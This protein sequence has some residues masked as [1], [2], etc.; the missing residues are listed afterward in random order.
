[1]DSALDE[2]DEDILVERKEDLI[3]LMGL[4]KPYLDDN[5]D[6]VVLGVSSDHGVRVDVAARNLYKLSSNGL[7]KLVEPY[8]PDS[9]WDYFISLHSLW[10]WV[11]FVFLVIMAVSIYL[12]PQ[13]YPLN[14]IRIGTSMVFTLYIPG[15][16]LIEALY[17]KGDDLER[18]ERFALSVGLSLA[19]VPLV[20]LVLN[21]TSFGI[22]L[23][24]S[25]LSLSTLVFILGLIAVYR[26][27]RNW[28]ISLR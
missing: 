24:P 6:S 16:T 20:G 11:I 27:Y 22:R 17:P 9:L 4:F 18:L 5:V 7:V 26:K 19:F 1:M 28:K 10:F 2:C 12:I 8:P 23:D 15:F 14:L 13:V 21:Y 3:P 25:F